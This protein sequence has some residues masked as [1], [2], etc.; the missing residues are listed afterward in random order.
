MLSFYLIVYEVRYLF[1]NNPTTFGSCIDKLIKQC[2]SAGEANGT[3]GFVGTDFQMP[4][5]YYQDNE[6]SKSSVLFHLLL[7]PTRTFITQIWLEKSAIMVMDGELPNVAVL[8][9]IEPL[10]M[11][12]LVKALARISVLLLLSNVGSMILNKPETLNTLSR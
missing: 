5:G 1:M 3:Y 6:K 8:V 7:K 10:Y 4:S 2:G 9:L 12:T 11:P